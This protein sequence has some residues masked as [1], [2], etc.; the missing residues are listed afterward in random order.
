MPPRTLTL[1]VAATIAFAFCAGTAHAD[2]APV[3]G[4]QTGDAQVASVGGHTRY[5]TVPASKGT[6]VQRL[7]RDGS[8]LATAHLAGWFAV[9]MVAFDGSTGGLSADGRT[10][11]LARPRVRFPQR[12]STL[13]ILATRPPGL[14][15]RRIIRLRGD[16]SF[17]A[18]SPDG[19]WIYLIQYVRVSL[20]SL[21][22]YQVRA[23][24]AVTGRLVRRPIVDPHD[25]G[26]PMRGDP[27]TRAI[28]PGGRWD[29][30]LYDDNGGSFIHALDTASLTARCVDLPTLG[31][32]AFSARLHLAGGGTRLLI[33]THRRVLA[34]ID[35]RTLTVIDPL[36]P[37]AAKRH[38]RRA[39]R[40]ASPSTQIL[41]ALAAAVALLAAAYFARVSSRRR[42]RARVTRL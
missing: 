35:T 22:V 11:V 2:G 9:P 34:V 41:I 32:D 21:P 4:Y 10:L 28:G 30:T 6:W 15:L 18:V 19:H 7:A 14:H 39:A 23:L 5:R 37:R 26:E 27:V 38:V 25:R 8:A 31:G 17:D 42:Q 29:Y 40:A 13:A 1:S 20:A 12:T 36:R 16:F 3:L 33:T 24:D